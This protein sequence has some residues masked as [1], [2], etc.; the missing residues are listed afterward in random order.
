VVVFREVFMMNCHPESPRRGF[1]LIELLVVI[2]IIGVLIA[3]LLPAVQS[4]REAA[5]RAQCINNLKQ[6][7]LAMHNYLSSNNTL[8]PGHRTAVFGT[9]QTFI[10]PYLEQNPLYGSYNMDGRYWSPGT[11]SGGGNGPANNLRYGSPC[12]LTVTRSIIASLLCPSDE[13]LPSNLNVYSGVTWHNYTVNFGN[14]DI[15][16]SLGP[17]PGGYSVGVYRDAPWLGAPFSDSDSTQNFYPTRAR[18]YDFASILD[19]T[20]NTLIAGEVIKGKG[21]DLRGFTWWGDAVSTSTYLTP[22]SSLPDIQNTAGYCIYPY[23]N[24][25]PCRAATTQFPPTYAFRS[26]HPGGVN[27]ALCDGSVKFIKNTIN[28]FVWRAL[29]TTQGSEVISA[30]SY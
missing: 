1:T 7:A 21:G 13:A 20:S 16:Q 3:L 17:V 12:N 25:P 29:G 27:V 28:L 22:N 2:A 26:R 9:F 23:S 6:V 18:T 4:A 5:R 10:L 30:D 11:T 19:G 14:A 24:N 15:Y 8:P